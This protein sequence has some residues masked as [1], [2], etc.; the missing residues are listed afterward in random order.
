M[1]GL[2]LVKR[3]SLKTCLG[4]APDRLH[5]SALSVSSERRLANADALKR[6]SSMGTSR[7]RWFQ[8]VKSPDFIHV[9]LTPLSPFL[10]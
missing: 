8:L 7:G 9:N 6:D 5:R 4:P 1:A 2:L 10:P 3:R